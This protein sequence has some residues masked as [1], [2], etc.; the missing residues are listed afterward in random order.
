MVQKDSIGIAL[1]SGANYQRTRTIPLTMHL[2]N[3]SKITRLAIP[4]FWSNARAPWKSFSHQV[5]S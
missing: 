1:E 5:M 4:G 2:I 3:V